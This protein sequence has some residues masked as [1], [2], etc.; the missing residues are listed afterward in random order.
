MGET[1][2]NKVFGENGVIC[3][4][5]STGA[6]DFAVFL[7]DVPGVFLFI[8]VGNEAKGIVNQ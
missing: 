2:L 4:T 3:P 6:E 1:P 5:L 8:G 7:E